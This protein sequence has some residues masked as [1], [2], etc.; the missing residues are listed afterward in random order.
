MRSLFVSFD[1]NLH[2]SEAFSQAANLISIFVPFNY[3]VGRSRRI[4]G[5]V[6]MTTS[7]KM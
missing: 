3:S 2:L 7:L 5:I 6:E 1:G 4:S